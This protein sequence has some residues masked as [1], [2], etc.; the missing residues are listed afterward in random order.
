V[1]RKGCW[2]EELGWK[3]KR[4]RRTG[5]KETNGGDE[6]RTGTKWRRGHGEHR[7]NGHRR[8]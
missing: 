8:E 7:Q 5:D 2:E 1:R 3:E 6:E 4:Y